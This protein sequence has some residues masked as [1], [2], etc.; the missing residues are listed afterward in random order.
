[1]DTITGSFK[2]NPKEIFQ[3]HKNRRDLNENSDDDLSLDDSYDSARY[4]PVND[5]LD[6]ILLSE[7]SDND[8]ISRNKGIYKAKH[9]QKIFKGL[10]QSPQS[11]KKSVHF[12]NGLVQVCEIDSPRNQKL[13]APRLSSRMEEKLLKH[14]KEDLVVSSKLATSTVM[15]DKIKKAQKKNILSPPRPPVRGNEKKDRRPP[16][17]HRN[18]DQAVAAPL[19]SPTLS[20]NTRG[21]KVSIPQEYESCDNKQFSPSSSRQCEC[22]RLV[23]PSSKTSPT[24]ESYEVKT[25]VKHA[26]PKVIKPFKLLTE[27]RAELR[28]LSI[29]SNLENVDEPHQYQ[30]KALPMPNFAYLH[31][32][33][34]ISRE[35]IFTITESFDFEL[36]K[37]FNGRSKP[38]LSQDDTN[39]GRYRFKASRVNDFTFRPLGSSHDVHLNAPVPAHLIL[40]GKLASRVK[41][42]STRGQSNL[43]DDNDVI[44]FIR[45]VHM[46]HNLQEQSKQIQSAAM[47]PLMR[48]QNMATKNMKTPP[49]PAIREKKSR[50]SLE[51][52]RQAKCS[53]ITRT[54][55]SPTKENP[56]FSESPRS[57]TAKKMPDFSK[58]F[59]PKKM[60]HRVSNS[61]I[62]RSPSPTPS[63]SARSK[64][65][66]LSS[67]SST[68]ASP[69]KSLAGS[70]GFKAK[71]MPD[72]SKP[73]VPKKNDHRIST[74]VAHRSPSPTPSSSTTPSLSYRSPSPTASR[75]NMSRL[76]SPSSSKGSP[77]FSE[78]PRSFLAKKMPDFSK[79]FIPK[80]MNNR[81]STSITNRS[82]SLTPPRPKSST[83]SSRSPSLTPSRSTTPSL[84]STS[85]NDGTLDNALTKSPGFKA[86]KM[87]DF[88]K[89]FI[90]K[91][92]DHHI[93]T[94]PV[95]MPDAASM[96]ESNK[97]QDMTQDSP[98]NISPL[99]TTDDSN[100]QD[101]SKSPEE[102]NGLNSNQ[103]LSNSSHS[104]DSKLSSMD[105]HHSNTRSSL[106]ED[107]GLSS[108]SLSS[109]DCSYS[110]TYDS[111]EE[112]EEIKEDAENELIESDENIETLPETTEPL[113]KVMERLNKTIDRLNEMESKRMT[114][115]NE[116][117]N[118]LEHT[119]K[120]TFDDI[121][122][123]S[124]NK[125]TKQQLRAYKGD[126]GDDFSS[127]FT[128]LFR[129]GIS[130][131]PTQPDFVVTKK[132]AVVPKDTSLPNV[133]ELRNENDASIKDDYIHS[134]HNRS[135]P[136]VDEKVNQMIRSSLKKKELYDYNDAKRRLPALHTAYSTKS[137]KETSILD[138]FMNCCTGNNEFIQSPRMEEWNVHQ[139]QEEE[140]SM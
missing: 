24:R 89:P 122:N 64:A 95:S 127:E 27:E 62:S 9:S 72:F 69:D 54:Y 109:S 104:Y 31:S 75:S 108:K 16:N 99:G 81:V 22:C 70:P 36:D 65:S 58:P 51:A 98:Q 33:F 61:T 94:D 49:K 101:K 4:I 7:S 41:L 29:Q 20:K 23:S 8:S 121:T 59:I 125:Y 78:S 117:P 28:K 133:T 111:D 44:D 118:R 67:P 100:E 13:I 55:R 38:K 85:S 10:S 138:R 14:M 139:D 37:R 2:V 46:S 35:K 68:K 5:S 112:N 79:P 30:F 113:I 76:S 132:Q 18:H 136:S 48:R 45:N 91:K 110:S 21:L 84:P 137:R 15:N 60:D 92:T 47:T 82:P 102:E 42:T 83:L 134:I 115:S 39:V 86:M 11:S 97:T 105:H 135:S 40:D 128:N 56:S 103:T 88:S 120:S 73:F 57:F 26:S 12:A 32:K 107:E 19:D 116:D 66:R 17:A 1:M 106:K 6:E 123:S 129:G 53:P 114:I 77:S 71:K 63:S 90:S 50:S 93:L 126:F 130:R 25:S 3:G 80:K 52:R 96:S 124:T 87:P 74:P 43:L 119:E 131:G 140:V 34:N